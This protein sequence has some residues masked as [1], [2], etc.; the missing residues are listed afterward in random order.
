MDRVLE[1]VLRSFIRHGTLRLTT[2]G[3]SILHFGDGTGEPIAVR[4]MTR[5]AQWWMLLDPE[6]KVGEAYMAGTLVME[7]GSIA[8][9]LHLAMSQDKSGKPP[10][11]AR[12]HLKWGEALWWSGDKAGA[13]KQ[14]NTAASLGLSH[15]EQAELARMER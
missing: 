10:H 3:G 7:R 1:F 6:L 8:D 2:A 12:L 9:F 5:A 4:F 11:W 14:W 15:D 13:R